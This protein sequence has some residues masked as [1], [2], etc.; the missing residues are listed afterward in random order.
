M[1]MLAEERDA[2]AIHCG[3][4]R[5]S[6]A[7]LGTA[8]FNVAS[9]LQQTVAAPHTFIGVTM[10]HRADY[11]MAAAG[12]L[13]SR[14]VY[15]PVDGKLPRE[16]IAH[17]IRSLGLQYMLTDRHSFEQVYDC[18]IDTPG[19]QFFLLEEIA[20]AAH[21]SQSRLPEYLPDD[22]VYVYFTSGSTG[23][24]KP[25]V[26][27]NQSLLHFLEWEIR[28]FCPGKGIRVSQFIHVGFDA[29]LRD[30]F[31]PL[32]SGGCVCIPE[33]IDEGLYE[34]ELEAWV[35][36]A[37]VELVHCVPSFFRL[38]NNK[39]IHPGSYPSLKQV[40]LSGEPVPPAS[41]ANWF[42][43]L[44]NRIRLVNLYGTTETTMIKTFYPIQPGDVNKKRIPAG[45]PIDHAQIILLNE[46]SRPCQ[47]GEEG[48]IYLQSADLSLGYYGDEKLNAEKFCM[49]AYAAGNQRAY[50]TGDQ[51]VFGEDGNLELLGRKDRQVKIRGIRIE[52]AEIEN[53][54]LMHQ[55]V[56]EAVAIARHE[57]DEE[58]I[59]C[60]YY[61]S[62]AAGQEEI[63]RQQLAV[64]L[65]DYMQPSYIIQVDKIPLLPNGKAD[66]RALPDPRS[67]IKD[68]QPAEMSGLAKT[69]IACWAQV[70]RLPVEK[71]GLQSNFFRLGGNSIQL[72]NLLSVILDQT[73]C[74]IPLEGFLKTPVVAYCVSRVGENHFT[75]ADD[76]VPAAKKN[77]YAVTMR[78]ERMYR[79][80]LHNG[81]ILGFNMPVVLEVRGDIDFTELEQLF[82]EYI[83]HQEVFRTSFV[84]TGEQVRQVVHDKVDFSIGI[85]VAGS[86]NLPAEV[87][88]CI[89]PFN[90]A[91]APLFRVFFIIMPDNR[92]FLVMDFHHIV[93]DAISMRVL[94][95]D[96]IALFAK[97]PLNST[98][99]FYKDYAEWMQLPAQ[100]SRMQQQK[101]YWLSEFSDSPAPLSLPYDFDR[102]G[103]K[104]TEG[105][106]YKFSA[107]ADLVVQLNRLAQEKSVTVFT[108]LLSCFYLL[109]HKLGNN[110][111][112]VVGIPTSGR[113]HQKTAGMLGL[114]VGELAMRVQ[115]QEEMQM[116]DLIRA[117]H[118]KGVAAF[119][120]QDFQYRD[121]IE[122]L[123]LDGAA[124]RNP[125]FD[126]WFSYQR[127]ESPEI[128]LRP[129]LTLVKLIND[130]TVA[131]FDL[132]LRVYEVEDVFELR[133]EYWT[134]LF[135][136]ETICQIAALYMQLLE[137]VA[138]DPGRPVSA[139]GMHMQLQLQPQGA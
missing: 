120:N 132:L 104:T 14:N 44:N 79:R 92:S 33:K 21:D 69:I 129:D 60:L 5:I 116:H 89:R 7:E 125:L 62:P 4:R 67:L 17:F 82:K 56:A 24:P 103:T 97:Q 54:V 101:T 6:Y 46:Q 75:E 64:Q 20:P 110:T 35:D 113:S 34:Q 100:Q 49:L 95:A 77:H 138:A 50:R 117:V 93:T 85:V 53:A 31:V 12:I 11:I 139:F 29:W 88:K 126:T 1:K 106:I 91:K 70:L 47:P 40:L 3:E 99:L 16:R 98:G 74:R 86:D 128:C 43:V 131:L 32:L 55:P 22:P 63:I 13:I 61:T 66:H 19:I 30:V 112:I 48:E 94:E 71:I 96:M 23:L 135:R 122:A 68:V 39:N 41:L 45:Q 57:P 130:N 52:P 87:G 59:I 136:E 10:Q 111:D 134:K 133:I 38:L 124:A 127:V 80:W 118:E 81:T 65:P 119:A 51:G 36:D 123:G 109:I 37:Q 8:S 15:V 105:K 107:D 137:Q 2:I 78:Q 72:L 115:V 102:P 42:S 27:R 9:L 108:L 26:G 84:N 58:A 28:T 121:L 18:G 76:F 114:F 90:L 25:V 83:R 73:D